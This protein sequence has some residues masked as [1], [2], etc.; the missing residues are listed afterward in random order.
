MC[1]QCVLHSTG[2][3]CP[4]NC[5]KT[6]RNGPCGGVREDGHCEVKPEMRCV[7]LKAYERSRPCRA[8]PGPGATSSTTCAAGRQPAQGTRRGSTLA[9][10]GDK[11]TPAGW[12]ALGEP[13][14]GLR[15]S[16]LPRAGDPRIVTAE[17]PMIDTGGLD[18]VRGARAN[19]TPWVD[20]INATDNTA[21]HAHASNVAIAIALK[22]R[23]RA[24]M[25]VVCRDKNRLA[26]QADIVGA[27]LF[28]VENICC[29]TGDD[30]TAGDEPEAR[31]VF[32]LDGPQLVKLADGL[33]AS[34]RYLSGR[35]L[36]PAPHLFVGAVENPGA[37]PFDYRAERAL[38]KVRAGAR[39]LQ[40]QI[41]YHPDRLEAFM[42]EVRAARRRRR[43]RVPA[44]D[45]PDPR[46]RALRFMTTTCP[47]SRARAA[48]RAVETA[49]D[50]EES[51]TSS[52]SSRPARAVAARRRRH[53][54]RRLPP[55]R[56]RRPAGHR[57]RHRPAPDPSRQPRPD[58]R[59][60]PHAHRPAVAV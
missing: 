43:G 13:A 6:L 7:W 33:L 22:A 23:R 38:K 31:R 12:A 55:R 56:Q 9:P 51:A 15:T 42:A 52:R 28:G 21:A 59:G 29:L 10:S 16:A 39:F 48:I 57:P 17:M 30:V 8:L 11:Q 46:P 1:G 53:A 18:A 36:D 2:M 35:K 40:L 32:D 47:A 27:A 14:R 37:P 5:P 24:V 4:M 26:L 19:L 34:G 3:T 49:S 45:L 25:Q 20:A 50:P 58:R 44:D 54:H 41:C 60:E